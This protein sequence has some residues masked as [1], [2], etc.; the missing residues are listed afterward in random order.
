M[1]A[2]YEHRSCEAAVFEWSNK[3]KITRL[4][5]LN[6]VPPKETKLEELLFFLHIPRTGG[7]AYHQW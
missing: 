7:R 6:S 1:A 5:E 2:H 3:E 4:K